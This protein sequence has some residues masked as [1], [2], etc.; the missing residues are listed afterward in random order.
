MH[1]RDNSD[2]E[3]QPRLRRR[4]RVRQ[5]TSEAQRENR[6]EIKN[7]NMGLLIS[8][9]AVIVIFCILVF[10]VFSVRKGKR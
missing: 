10:T 1:M 2:L 6:V 3:G 5:M 9:I 4:D 8:V 7:Q